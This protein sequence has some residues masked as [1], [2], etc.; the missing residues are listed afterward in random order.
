MKKRIRFI[1]AAYVLA[2][3]AA[4]ALC[5]FAGQENIVRAIE[6]FKNWGLTGAAAFITF[7][8]FGT[9]IFFPVTLLAFSSGVIYGG[10]GG[11]AAAIFSSTLG[12]CVAFLLSRYFCRDW[13]QK[14]MTESA[15]FRA[16][17]EDVSN[18]GWKIVALSRVSFILPYTALNYAF[19][20]TRIPFSQYAWVSLIAMI[21]SSLLYAYL[22][23]IAGSVSLYFQG[24]KSFTS[25]EIIFA[26]VTLAG[27]LGLIIYLGSI[28]RNAIKKA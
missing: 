8:I 27:S 3:I 24:K 6:S 18:R 15:K 4:A 13:I 9:L 17:E 22:G 20:L 12:A 7:F 16:F 19:G 21:P 5:F 1:A 28:L 14:K 10:T 25:L 23:S 2:V 26:G 11:F